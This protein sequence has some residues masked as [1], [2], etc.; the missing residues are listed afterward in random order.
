MLICLS[1]MFSQFP[2]N[3]YKFIFYFLLCIG[4]DL[5]C[6]VEPRLVFIFMNIYSDF[7]WLSWFSCLVLVA[8]M[9][10]V[11]INVWE[12][13]SLYKYTQSQVNNMKV[14]CQ[15]TDCDSAEENESLL[16][17][18]FAREVKSKI[19]WEFMFRSELDSLFF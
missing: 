4:K 15:T 16:H 18:Q 6:S 11:W 8:Q 13:T 17:K 5:R 12:A 3:N 7:Q 10:F 1:E 14:P 9:S 19:H 2:T